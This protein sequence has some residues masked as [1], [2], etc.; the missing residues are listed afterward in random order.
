LE[1]E[2]KKNGPGPKIKEQIHEKNK[3]QIPHKKIASE[4]K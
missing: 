4:K 2:P 3:T 1:A